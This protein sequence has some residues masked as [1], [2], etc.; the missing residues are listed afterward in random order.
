MLHNQQGTRDE[1]RKTAPRTDN[2]H[3]D[4]FCFMC[5]LK[6]VAASAALAGMVQGTGSVNVAGSNGDGI[7]W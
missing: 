5:C 1:G 4:I 6:G 3:F 2:S 7:Y